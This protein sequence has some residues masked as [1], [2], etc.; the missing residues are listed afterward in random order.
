MA[1]IASTTILQIGLFPNF[2]DV[3]EAEAEAEVAVEAVVEDED[4]AVALKGVDKF[5]TL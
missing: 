2:P 4:V 3:A 5:V 1:T